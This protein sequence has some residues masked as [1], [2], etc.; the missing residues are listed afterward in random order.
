MEPCSGQ[1]VMPHARPEHLTFSSFFPPHLSGVSG[2]SGKE[3]ILHI[4]C[5]SGQTE[6]SGCYSWVITVKGR[7]AAR[8]KLL[9]QPLCVFLFA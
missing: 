7:S 5:F 8:G 3:K 9:I 4:V 2:P 1:V 6:G